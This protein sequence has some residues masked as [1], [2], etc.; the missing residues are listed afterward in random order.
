MSKE[1]RFK[2][3]VDAT[4]KVRELLYGPEAYRNDTLHKEFAF[5]KNTDFK[6]GK[7]AYAAAKN[8]AETL[9]DKASS[10]S[11]WMCNGGSGVGNYLKDDANLK[12][13]EGWDAQ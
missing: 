8:Y 1:S 3:R 6:T 2:V 12:F 11:I 9:L 13:D 5:G 7:L 4:R 10:V